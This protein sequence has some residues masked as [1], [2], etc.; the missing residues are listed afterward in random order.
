MFFVFQAALNMV[1][2]SMA[3]DL[4]SDKILSVAIHP[5]WVKTDMGGPNAN[6]TS[7]KSVEGIIKVLSMLK[8]EHNGLLIDYEGKTLPW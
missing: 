3:V 5:G 8:D 4:K 7:T 2:K 1:T 6:L